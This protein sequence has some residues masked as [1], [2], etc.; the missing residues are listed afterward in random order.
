MQKTKQG[1]S[2]G[3]KAGKEQKKVAMPKPISV[4]L[5]TLRQEAPKDFAGV[6][7]RIAEIGYKGVEPA[8]FHNLNAKEFRKLVDDLGLVVSSSHGPWGN[9][10]NINECVEIAGILG[11]DMV[12]GGYGP[13]NYKTLDAI[14]Q[15]A[16]KVNARVA[17]LK[18]HGLG[19]FL[20]NHWWEFEMVEGRLAYDRFAEL[21]PDV[22]FEIDTYWC[23]NFGA[24]DPA[25]Q[26]AKFKHRTPLLHIKDGTLKKDV[27]HL[28]VGKGKMDFRKVVAAADPA[29]LRWM[30]VELDNC[31]TDMFQA[32]ADSYTYLTSTGLAAGNR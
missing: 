19:L 4:Q 22:L 24:N 6:L 23:A 2:A 1:P 25:A 8:G 26:V 28:A 17:A 11:L 15:T 21:C 3:A 32:V 29:I 12:C 16:E 14:K 20:H 10:D 13:D 5:Y 7:R 9:P 18:K 31:A 27:P 30:V